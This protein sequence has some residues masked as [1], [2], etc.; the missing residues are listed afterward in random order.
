MTRALIVCPGRGSYARETLGYLQGRTGK[1]ADYVDAAD[2]LRGQ[3]GVPTVRELDALPAFSSKSHVAGE[4][5]SLLTSTCSLADFGDLRPDVRV[6]GV[7]GNSMG[8]YTALGVAGALPIGEAMRL[9][10]TMGAWQAGN[11]IGG[12][13]MYPVTH[14]DWTPD[15]A[16]LEH[17][18]LAL[19]AARDAGHGAWWSIRLGTFAVLGADEGGLAFLAA[20]LVPETRGA[21]TFPVKLPLHSAF[22]TPLLADTSRRAIAA[23]DD[24]PFQAPR[25]PLIDGRG[26]VFWPLHAD[27]AE[28]FDYTLGHQVVAPYDFAASIE[29]ALAQTGPDV[30][31]LLGPGNPLGGA[32]AAAL[33][34]AGWRGMRDRADFE[35]VQASDTPVL[36]SMG[37]PAQRARVV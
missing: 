28:L 8:W 14:P 30:V 26:R 32:A 33:I 16:R 25:V 22:H 20:R 6:C 37:V 23:L 29:T 19:Q 36:V 11:V 24:L 4:N 3:R 15:P 18:E 5:A 1:A 35:A 31:V 10:E 12:Q 13:L 27:P 2:A 17:V 9:V 21:Q 7:V 34:R